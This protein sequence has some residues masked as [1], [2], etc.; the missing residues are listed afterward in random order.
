MGKRFV[1]R[2][3]TLAI[4]LS[5][6]TPYIK[7]DNSYVSYA[8]HTIPAPYKAGDLLRIAYDDD[9]TIKMKSKDI[10]LRSG[11]ILKIVEDPPELGDFVLY[12]RTVT[13]LNTTYLYREIIV[14]NP[15]V[16]ISFLTGSS[17]SK[18]IGKVEK[19]ADYGSTY[20]YIVDLVQY[21][22]DTFKLSNFKLD[23]FSKNS[24]VYITSPHY[25]VGDY[26]IE[27]YD[28]TIGYNRSS[29]FL[30]KYDG[31]VYPNRTILGKVE[32]FTDYVHAYYG[33][34]LCNIAENVIEN[35][36]KFTRRS[37]IPS[38]LRSQYTFEDALHYR[39]P[40][41][42]TALNDNRIAYL[43]TKGTFFIYDPRTDR[44]EQKASYP[45]EQLSSDFRGM[46]QYSLATLS[47]GKVAAIGGFYTTSKFGWYYNIYD[48]FI[49]DVV[50][51]AWT[52]RIP[53]ILNGYPAGKGAIGLD[54]NKILVSGGEDAAD[55]DWWT[56][57]I[58]SFVIDI[59]SKT[60]Q[61]VSGTL[62]PTQGHG[63]EGVRA[64]KLS[65]GNILLLG[66]TNRGYGS[67]N[68]DILE[69]DPS[70]NALT[71]KEN[72]NTLIGAT[73]SNSAGTYNIGQIDTD[74]FLVQ[75]STSTYK[76]DKV[77]VYDATKN[78]MAVL[79]IFQEPFF[80]K[81]AYDELI[82]RSI[83]TNDGTVVFLGDD[84]YVYTAVPNKKPTINITSPTHNQE[85]Q[86]GKTLNIKWTA[87]DQD[88]D[89][90]TYKVRVY[91]ENNEYYSGNPNG[92]V[93]NTAGQHNFN[94]SNI[95]LTYN[96]VTGRYEK[97]VK[98]DVS[99]FDGAE[100]AVAT[101]EFIV[102]NYVPDAIITTPETIHVIN[103]KDSFKL[104]IKVWDVGA[105]K[106]TV[107]AT[108]NGKTK[109][110]TINSAPTTTPSTDNV[111]LTWSG[112]SALDAGTY[113]DIPITI[114]DIDGVT[115]T[116]I[117]KGTII[118]MDILTMINDGISKTLLDS[119]HD[120]RFVLVNT[121]SSIENS[122]RNTQL[123]NI[124]KAKLNGRGQSVLWLGKSDSK[125]YI[126]SQLTLDNY[127]SYKFIPTDAKT[128]IIE[129][130]MSIITEDVAGD[131]FVVGDQIIT[132]M[133][134][135]D[136]EKDY[137]G[138]SREDKL[139]PN[140]ELTQEDKKPKEGTLQAKYTHDPTLFD[141]PVGKHFSA[142]EEWHSISDMNDPFIIKEAMESM[143]GLWTLT[144]QASD[145]TKNPAFDKYATPK[146]KNFIIHT[147]PKAIA[148]LYESS[149]ELFLSAAESYD[150][151][152]QYFLPNN[153][154][155]KYEWFYELSDGSIHKYPS[156]NKY[157]I[158]PRHM[159]GKEVT[160]FTLTVYDCYGAKDSTNITGLLT[161]AI[162]AELHPELEKFDIF[163]EGIPASE[164]L[165]VTNIVTLP[166]AMDKLEFAL[167]KNGT[168]VTPIRTLI[169]PGDIDWID[170]MLNYWKDLRNYTIPATLQ[171]GLYTAKIKGIK[172]NIGL[173]LEK[174][175]TLRINTPINLKPTMPTPVQ[176]GETYEI[177]AITSKYADNVTVDIFSDGNIRDMQLVNQE[178]D[179]K[180]WRLSFIAP[181]A[182]PKV[183]TAR[184]R[185][186]TPNGNEEIKT[187]NF[188][189][190]ILDLNNLRITNMVNHIEYEGQ[191]PILYNDPKVPVNY[192]A[193][194]YVIFKINAVGSP[195]Y[196]RMKITY[197]G[198]NQEFNMVKESENDLDSVWRLEWYSDPFVPK[199]TLIN[200]NISARKNATTINFNN[201]YSWDGNY[202]RVS[203]SIEGDWRIDQEL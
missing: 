22:R 33:T 80:E 169:N 200:T 90:L 122:A 49:Y 156:E 179:I 54:N 133:L 12:E 126:D 160:G 60:S 100:G 140:T 96:S 193:G 164:E 107:S 172:D 79:P 29:Y 138:I 1:A 190:Q 84:G 4:L 24:Y 167:Y 113:T 11:N 163:G 189:L 62:A 130:I 119:T 157:I 110:A 6:F 148:N 150:L 92:S 97:K 40:I 8:N 64:F 198:Y 99:V 46:Q 42:G 176:A 26:V 73:N 48:I 7:M 94:T 27:R 9:S 106:V 186:T 162:Q 37:Q 152:F 87:S 82:H 32:K 159:S 120:N 185:A 88:N 166:Y 158:L 114:T 128:S 19:V 63:Y 124:I 187:R 188:T 197:P 38:D 59:N 101:R 35:K 170:V 199:G 121:E 181:F 95:P 146:T 191:Y 83:R 34:Y 75:N 194:Y 39:Y 155:V 28:Y 112:T 149:T 117:W 56:Y 36:Y 174:S 103:Y 31:I 165:K 15:N 153:G 116:K 66:G 136:Y 65:N 21:R 180:Y 30:R 147:A 44:W 127:Y 41:S 23:N 74:K 77:Y 51:D 14:Y 115:T 178:N 132:E 137:E 142:D 168:R 145:T 78:E 109:S 91:D 151:D 129:F 53:N 102:V 93:S 61:V 141:N 3:L 139:K 71:I 10:E 68:Y 108:I 105:D 154:I 134:F 57:D 85:V 104:N 182:E 86:K 98:V 202:L 203:G 123:L 171:D 195:D 143:R 70:T 5:L 161:P 201:K 2:V 144:L 135:E 125:S 131:I 81:I 52:Q 118:V 196:V 13:M 16:S 43:S 47:N 175:W 173:E 67:T 76:I 18:L 184:F 45:V 50:L 55:D 72:L 20:K 69:Y 25:N 58:Y 17:R 192:K 177:T 111:T 183:Y 89:N